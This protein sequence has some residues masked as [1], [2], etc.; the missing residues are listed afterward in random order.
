MESNNV[1]LIQSQEYINLYNMWQD[2]RGELRHLY[3]FVWLLPEA[4]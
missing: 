3:M 4:C 1:H 2:K